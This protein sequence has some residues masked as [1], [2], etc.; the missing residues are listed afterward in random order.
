MATLIDENNWK[1][2]ILLSKVARKKTYELLYSINN[3]F[4]KLLYE[5]HIKYL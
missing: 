1:Y 4:P 2:V 5:N 3:I